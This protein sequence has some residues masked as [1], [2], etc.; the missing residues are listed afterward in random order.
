VLSLL[1]ISL[2]SV[3]EEPLTQR[4]GR[5]FKQRRNAALH[6][7]DPGNIHIDSGNI[8]IDSENIR[9]I[10]GTFALIR[11]IFASIQGTFGSIRG[12][13]GSIQG[14]FGS[15]QGTFTRYAAWTLGRPFS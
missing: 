2:A 6:L 9:S 1:A 14:T 8:R 15:I 7:H 12:T 5:P 13:F 3:F 10:Q 4:R 11:G